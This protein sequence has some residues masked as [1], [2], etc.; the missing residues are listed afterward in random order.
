MLGCIGQALPDG[1]EIDLGHDP[2]LETAKWFPLSYIQDILNKPQ[3]GLHD[4]PAEGHSEDD[5]RIPPPTAIAHQ[6]MAAVAKGFHG[7]APK[8]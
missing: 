5:I 7:G 4:K 3:S 1:E 8:M 2:E 6:L